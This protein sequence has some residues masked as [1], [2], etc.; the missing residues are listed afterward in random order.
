MSA[1]TVLIVAQDMTSPLDRRVW[2]QATSLQNHGYRVFVLCPNSR[3]F[4]RITE[5]IDGIRIFRYPH[6]LEGRNN[7]GIFL[8][9]LISTFSIFTFEIILGIRYKIDVLHLCNPPDFLYQASIGIRLLRNPK[10]VWDQHDVVPELWLAKKNSQKSVLYK[11]LAIF[12]KKVAKKSDLV[13]FASDGF[14]KRMF[15]RRVNLGNEVV[16]IKTSPRENFGHSQFITKLERKLQ[17]NPKITIVYLGRMGS[18]DGIETLI[19]AFSIVLS[20]VSNFALELTLIGDGPE[21]AE[22][23]KKSRLLGSYPNTQ[24]YG[25]IS[26]ESELC[27]LLSASDIAVCPDLPNG[28][29]EISSMNKVSEYL[30]MGLPIVQFNLEENVKTAQ[31]CTV[32]AYHNNSQ[33]LA[34]A[35]IKL[36]NDPILR[37]NLSF[38]SRRRFLQ[39]LT[40]EVQEAKLIESYRR[41]LSN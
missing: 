17:A 4:P 35:M 22:L 9:Y 24:F 14:Q 28:M 18:Q 34:E 39:A 19:E 41:L 15:S 16:V 23:E 21:R 30:A 11:F 26:D 13:I 3:M 27:K 37:K 38:Q 36:I 31:G 33:S 32:I 12:E 8:E 1:N 10:V 25:Y 2:L 20:Q 6:I 7:L 5:V 40:W 29:N